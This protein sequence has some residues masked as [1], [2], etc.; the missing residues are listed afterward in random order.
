MEILLILLLRLLVPL[1]IL[2]WPLLG[3]FLAIGADGLD[4]LLFQTSPFADY[5]FYQKLDKVL[6]VYYLALE[7]YVV[8]NLWAGNIL[9]IGLS[10][11]AY[12]FIGIV[13]FL[14]TSER[15]FL[16]FFPNLF[17]SFYL[18]VLVY[19]RLI[20]KDFA[21]NPAK[22]RQA[23]LKPAQT[24]FVGFG[25]F[26]PKMMQELSIHILKATPWELAVWFWGFS[27]VVYYYIGQI[28]WIVLVLGFPLVFLVSQKKKR[29]SWC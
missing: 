6:D 18:F 13:I 3:G 19:R 12:R 7:A 27:G 4:W 17:E 9:R 28:M 15:F 29:V 25:L 21:L 11:F 23:L 26:L 10:L 20:R 24:A 5:N 22:R 8:S 1:T 14:I 16:F 2:R